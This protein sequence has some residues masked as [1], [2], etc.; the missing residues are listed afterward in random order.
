ME[1]GGAFGGKSNE[2]AGF[3][4]RERVRGA[5]F[6]QVFESGSFGFFHVPSRKVKRQGSCYGYG[7]NLRPAER[8]VYS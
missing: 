5:A 6:E 8:F 2:N 1:L 7:N 3:V 4:W